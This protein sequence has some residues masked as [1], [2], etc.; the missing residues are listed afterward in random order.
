MAS[1]AEH[2]LI[3][4]S[5][6]ARAHLDRLHVDPG[7]FDLA[8][9]FKECRRSVLGLVP[10]GKPAGTDQFRIEQP[11]RDRSFELCQPGLHFLEFPTERAALPQRGHH[12]THAGERPGRRAATAR[13]IGG[14]RRD[15]I[16]R[17][18]L[19]W[20]ARRRGRLAWNWRRGGRE[21][22]QLRLLCDSLHAAL[23]DSTGRLLALS[24]HPTPCR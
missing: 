11:H 6:L 18:A 10:I 3:G 22:D 16:G 8:L 1:M 7:L 23:L 5:L 20:L 17:R 15:A 19:S 21:I 24:S 13:R 9:E 4:A 2:D 14:C 12:C